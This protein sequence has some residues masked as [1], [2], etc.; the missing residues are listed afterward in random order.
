MDFELTEEQKAIQKLAREF[1][2]REFPDLKAELGEGEFP[3]KTWKM[4]C[5]LGLVGARIPSRHGGAGVDVQT[6]LLIE[7]E[8][9]RINPR[10]AE[11]ITFATF[12]SDLIRMFGTEEQGEKYLRPLVEGKARMSSALEPE[13]GKPK[14]LRLKARRERGGWVIDGV[15]G[16]PAGPLPD[17]IIVLCT[18]DE[19][20]NK[21]SVMVVETSGGGIKLVGKDHGKEGLAKLSFINV[22]VDERNLVGKEGEGTK[23]ASEFLILSKIDNAAQALGIAEGAF[24]RATRYIHE[25]EGVGKPTWGYSET[26]RKL[27]EIKTEIETARLLTRKAAWLADRGE[28]NPVLASMAEWK[29]GKVA[30][31]SA[32]EATL[33]HEGT[34]GY[35]QDYRVER[36][37]KSAGVTLRFPHALSRTRLTAFDLLPDGLE[38][39]EKWVRES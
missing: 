8:F 20:K 6:S 25:R 18:A 34:W 30:V 13:G 32:E 29:A 4:A 15:V 37:R 38:D 35:I 36:F 7:E 12:G 22:E 9:F 1:A 27:A 28:M 3:T 31:M 21:T 39:V 16:I 2:K 14:E 10:L 5:E 23:L 11:A 33:L 24:E 17:F 26:S 19:L